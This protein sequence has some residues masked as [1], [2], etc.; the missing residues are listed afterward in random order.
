M[1][2]VSIENNELT[3]KIKPEWFESKNK[4]WGSEHDFGIV[5]NIYSACEFLEESLKEPSVD[6][7][8]GYVTPVENM[9]MDCIQVAFEDGEEWV[10]ESEDEE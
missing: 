6:L 3:I 7:G 1:I 4:D 9:L 2:N 5:N 8:E 10:G